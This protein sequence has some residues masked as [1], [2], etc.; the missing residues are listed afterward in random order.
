MN[1]RPLLLSLLLALP[2]AAQE[3]PYA[4]KAGAAKAVITPAEL[5]WMDGYAAR[6]GPA[7]MVRQ[8]LHAKA[9]ALEDADGNR[10]VFITLDL[11]GV[12]KALRLEI[13]KYAA[14]QHGLT[15]SNLVLNASHTHCGPTIRLYTP[16]GSTE[17]RLSS[18]NVPDADQPMR[19]RQVR[20]YNAMLREKLHQIIDQALSQLAPVTLTW[21][22]S[23]C[24]FSMNRRTPEGA[25]FKNF[26]NP[27]GPVD[28]EVPV[29]A[30][31][32]GEKNE[33]LVA[34]MFGYACHATTLSINEINGD[35]PGY[36][37][38][39]FEEDH[40]G[41]VALFLNGCSGDQNPYPRRFFPYVEKHG[42]AM[43][44]SIEAALETV[45]RPVRGPLKTALEWTEIDYA[46][47]PTREELMVR[48]QSKDRYEQT[49]AQF[50]LAELDAVGSLP[51]SYPVPV[52]AIQ[53][54][55][56]LTMVTIGGEVTVDYSLRLKRELYAKSSAAVWVAG[57]SN[58]VMSYIPS[59]R[60][61]REGGYEGASSMRYGRSVVHPNSW[62]PGIEER[63][64]GTAHRLLESL[65][66]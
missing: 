5:G 53:F 23:R 54:G 26:P 2:L 66:P 57:Y 36:A 40:P 29:L 19:V 37:Q 59:E 24:G 6:T 33:Q 61:L 9:L 39:Y 52:Q 22:H 18:L 42:R 25:D 34:V 43:A 50:L 30:V 15:A 11:I 21:Q 46:P 17:E 16:R 28:Q 10:L 55:D 63:I 45:P 8:D 32:R 7:E 49:Y 60:V 65:T 27:E 31:R 13:E 1:L 47:A 51:K 56:T 41:T 35:W 38:Q 62:A 14:D 44:T 48:A 4:W 64:V 58:D 3:A 20:E 12:P